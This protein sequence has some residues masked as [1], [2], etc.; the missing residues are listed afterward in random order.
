VLITV[1][2]VL[3]VYFALYIVGTLA[4]AAIAGMAARRSQH[5][6]LPST[7]RRLMRAELAPGISVCLAAYN[8]SAVI[9]DTIR[10][11][12][13]LDYPDVE[14]VLANDGSTDTTL[15]MLRAEFGLRP[16]ERPS[17]GELPHRPIRA[18]Y[19]PRAPI[20]L[21][22][23][24][25]ENGG[26]S[27]SL[28][29]AIR[30]AHGPLVAVM[31]ADELVANSTLARA[32]RPFVADPERTVAAGSILGIAN[33]CRT[34]RGRIIERARPR[35]LLPLFQAVEYERSFRISRI[36]AGSLRALPII[37]GGFGIFR[38]DALLAVGGYTSDTVGEDF[39][40]TLRIH[41]HFDDRG[42]PHR[43]AQIPNAVCWTRVPDSRRLLRR[44]RM[45]WHRGLGQV[46]SK[47]RG[48]L[49]RRRY[50]VL[51]AFAVP[52][53]WAYE[54]VN[55]F[56]V[57]LATVVTTLCIAI[58][59]MSWQQLLLGVFITWAVVVAP[60][61]AS[62]LMTDFPAESPRGWRNLAAIVGAAF[63]EIP[64]Q[65]LTLAFRL[66]SVF[67]G[68]RVAWG[69]MERSVGTES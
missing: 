29:A 43:V 8:E 11:L 67:R 62:L 35:Q 19:E 13:A 23:I 57:I 31:D 24:D 26:R 33:G 41:R 14:V 55:P 40:I 28:N 1:A 39:D 38:R 47:H 25:K 4:L 54:L 63:V 5:E 58:G 50:G 27:D 34:L 68:R 64:Y 66:E 3:A 18:L 7:L 48:M 52:W 60:T 61:L 51:G 37:S 42:L 44:Q 30:Y 59:L 49:F 45:R 16:C 65:I 6:L 10:S 56:V 69:D 15:E 2:W 17:F 46:L 12:L 22:V 9:V 21:L 32:V 20:P 36:A 53:A